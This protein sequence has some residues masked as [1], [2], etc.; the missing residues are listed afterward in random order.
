VGKKNPHIYD[1][2]LFLNLKEAAYRTTGAYEK[3]DDMT[4]SLG[5]WNAGAA[6]TTTTTI[7]TRSRFFRERVFSQ[8]MG[9]NDFAVDLPGWDGDE[10][11]ENV[12]RSPRQDGFA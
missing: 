8:T 12:A 9:D 6:Q 7:A 4:V 1:T 2:S 10:E 3:P 11:E 5:E